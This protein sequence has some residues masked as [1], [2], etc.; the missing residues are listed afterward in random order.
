MPKLVKSLGY[1]KCYSSS[2]PRPVK[3]LAIL[4]NVY[5]IKVHIFGD[6]DSSCCANHA[7]KKTVRDHFNS[8]NPPT[9]ESEKNAKEN[10]SKKLEWDEDILLKL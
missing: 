5:Q 4:S 3:K 6:K 9:I 1:I 10:R 2:S 8:Y 7:I